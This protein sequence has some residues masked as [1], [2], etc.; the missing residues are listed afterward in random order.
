MRWQPRAASG[1]SGSTRTGGA[2]LDDYVN[3]SKCM[4]TDP[5]S[6]AG[7]QFFADLME[8]G[9]AMRPADLNQAGGD[10]ASS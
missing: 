4:L 2:I 7:I 8:Q 1:A 6:V 5:A 10:A 3:P 9:Y